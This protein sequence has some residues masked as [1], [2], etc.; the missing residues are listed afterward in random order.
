[1]VCPRDF[2]GAQPSTQGFSSQI[3]EKGSDLSNKLNYQIS[4]K[5]SN[6]LIIYLPPINEANRFLIWGENISVF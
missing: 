3:I 1:M 6:V 2:Y 4:L 5:M